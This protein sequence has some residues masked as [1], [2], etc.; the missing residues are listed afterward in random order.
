MLRSQASK[1]LDKNEVRQHLRSLQTKLHNNTLTRSIKEV[2][3]RDEVIMVCCCNLIHKRTRHSMCKRLSEHVQSRTKR[4]L[5]DN[6]LY[7]N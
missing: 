5:L 3:T 1:T 7:S 6:Y 4:S 2:E